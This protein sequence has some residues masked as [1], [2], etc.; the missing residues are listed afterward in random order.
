M[1]D[2][3]TNRFNAARDAARAEKLTRVAQPAGGMFGGG[4]AAA[5][6]RVQAT[7]PSRAVAGGAL[8]GGGAFPG[9]TPATP[10]PP[11][12]GGVPAGAAD[13]LAAARATRLRDISNLS[14]RS[15]A[16]MA[17]LAARVGA[18]PPLQSQVP[19]A[20]PNPFGW[21]DAGPIPEGRDPWNFRPGAG[22]G[23]SYGG[24]PSGSSASGG[25]GLPGG[26]TSIR[27]TFDGGGPGRS[28][29]TF[30]GGGRISSGLNSLGVSPSR[31]RG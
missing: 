1:A 28:G 16:V 3:P 18:T 27:D 21:A 14:A 26:Y 24:R 11:A 20:R 10:A 8:F 4:A 23:G 7:A 30:Q 31:P 15:D 2:A 6:V 22:D 13:A 12:T 17:R 9:R 19:G 29:D 25:G 5:P